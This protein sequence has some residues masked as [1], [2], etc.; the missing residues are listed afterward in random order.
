L[1]IAA[2]SPV[3]RVTG[4][5]HDHCC[6]DRSM[7]KTRIVVLLVFWGCGSAEPSAEVAD[8]AASRVAEAGACVP[9]AVFEELFPQAGHTDAG[10]VVEQCLE[11][12]LPLDSKGLPN[13]VVVTASDPP[14]DEQAV[15][16]CNRC[17]TPGLEP[18]VA[19]IPLDSIGESISNYSC[20]CAIKPPSSM[21][22][23][24]APADPGGAW[25][26]YSERPPGPPDLNNCAPRPGPGI[27][28][29]PAAQESGTVYVACFAMPLR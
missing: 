14:G 4:G 1:R 21:D 7:P 17:D 26:C 9:T 23:P 29:S 24:P 15:L 2:L 22:C 11:A 16:D 6:R 12:A 28:L 27:W 3:I 5:R 8:G 25:W 10:N 13:C 18:L 19:T 20:I